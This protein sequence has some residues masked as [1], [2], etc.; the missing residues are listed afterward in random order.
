MNQRSFM[1]LRVIKSYP[2]SIT[3]AN[4]KQIHISYRLRHCS[5]LVIRS[6]RLQSRANSFDL[7][8]SSFFILIRFFPFALADSSGFES[9]VR[10]DH[11]HLLYIS[12]LSSV[13]VPGESAVVVRTPRLS[14][15]EFCEVENVA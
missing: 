10:Y 2:M 11:L 15:S 5:S 3:Y 13:A 8:K 9:R 4:A 12:P 1:A 6:S 14:R 7:C